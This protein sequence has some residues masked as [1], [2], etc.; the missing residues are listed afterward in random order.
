VDLSARSSVGT[1]VAIVRA[2]ILVSGSEATEVV[3]RHGYK[4]ARQ[5]GSGEVGYIRHFVATQDP[6]RNQ[7]QSAC[8]QPTDDAVIPA[9]NLIKRIDHATLNICLTRSRE[10]LL[11]KAG[12]RMSNRNHIRMCSRD[13]DRGAPHRL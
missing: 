4:L 12:K 1:T 13:T 7:Q 2:G 5:L 8:V 3:R 6:R 9:G 10:M 11:T